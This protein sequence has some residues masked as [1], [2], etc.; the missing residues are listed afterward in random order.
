[1]FIDNSN[2]EENN[3]KYY[4]D[5]MGIL[6]LMYHRFNEAKYPSTNIEMRVFKDQIKIIKD[7]RPQPR[8]VLPA[9]LRDELRHPAGRFR[10]D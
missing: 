9:R 10:R 2:A 8:R 3:I 7:S 5:D 4:S 1:M 6:S